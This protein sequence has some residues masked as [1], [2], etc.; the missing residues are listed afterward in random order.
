MQTYRIPEFVARIK[1]AKLDLIVLNPGPTLGYITGLHFHLMERPIL[2]LISKQG[3]AAI[4]LPELE[5]SKV[6]NVLPVL[7]CFSYGDDPS[8][9]MELDQKRL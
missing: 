6:A 5:V 2:F 1:N 4:V 7:T 3:K 9:W 8:K